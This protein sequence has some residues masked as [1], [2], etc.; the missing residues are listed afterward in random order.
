MTDTITRAEFEAL[1]ARLGREIRDLRTELR[2]LADLVRRVLDATNCDDERSVRLDG[3]LRDWM[4]ARLTPEGQ[5]HEAT[6]RRMAAQFERD[7]ANRQA[8]NQRLTLW[9]MRWGFWS[10]VIG[11]IVA[12]TS[13]AAGAVIW[14]LRWINGGAP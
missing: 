10:A 11:G 13:G 2:D 9:A 7:E 5:S 14:A 8:A 6:L 1:E 4:A 3:L 12:F